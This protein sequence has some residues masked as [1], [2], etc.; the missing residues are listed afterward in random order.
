MVDEFTQT[1]LGIMVAVIMLGLGASL[2]PRDFLLALKRP[3]GL[4]IGVVAQ[5]GIMPFLGFMFVTF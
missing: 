5:Y 4:M 3:Q 1:L 2:T